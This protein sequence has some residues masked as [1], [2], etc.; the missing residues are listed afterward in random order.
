[1][2]TTWEF[3]S[4]KKILSVLSGTTLE[5]LSQNLSRNPMSQPDSLPLG[6]LSHCLKGG[7][8]LTYHGPD[9]A[10][11]SHCLVP[12]DWISKDLGLQGGQNKIYLALDKSSL[13]PLRPPKY[14]RPPL[15]LNLSLP[16]HFRHPLLLSLAM[17]E[18]FWKVIR[19]NKVLRVGLPVVSLVKME[20]E[21]RRWRRKRK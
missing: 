4:M 12:L 10:R 17:V 11:P 15:D 9:C 6:F 14:P 18:L 3:P 7:Q 8:V 1:M 2:A 13:F 5:I 19:I 20:M 21:M 16:T